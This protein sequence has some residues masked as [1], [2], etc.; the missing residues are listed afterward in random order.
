MWADYWR[1]LWYDYQH[2]LSLY[3]FTLMKETTYILDK[4][5]KYSWKDFSLFVNRMR[6]FKEKC[7]KKYWDD[8]EL[9]VEILVEWEDNCLDDITFISSNEWKKFDNNIFIQVKTKWWDENNTIYKADGIF[10]AISN[11]LFNLNFQKDKLNENIYFFIFTNKPL[12]NSL[13]DEINR[14]WPDLYLDFVNHISWL[15]KSNFYPKE[16]LEKLN[17]SINH[18]I[19]LRL[20][21]WKSV[22]E[23]KYM[24][25]Y[26]EDYLIKLSNLVIDLKIV[27]NNLD[28]ITKIDHDILRAELKQFYWEVIYFRERERI[29]DLCGKWVEINRWTEEF[30]KYEDYKFTFF[31]P[32]NGWQTIDKI[33]IITKWKFI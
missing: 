24:K 16:P 27:F 5:K 1:N 4:T 7:I 11:F 25:Y 10:K 8:F 21:Q 12:A 23:D 29:T 30:E 9:K 22:L 28:I 6:K 32:K 26:T 2:V 13:I 18:E 31:K 33:D 15:W 17:K 20:L 19:I 14:N 3:L